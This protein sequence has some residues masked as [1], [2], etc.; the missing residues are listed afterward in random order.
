MGSMFGGNR[1]SGYN[2]AGYSG[3]VAP[4]SSSLGSSDLVRGR[5]F[6]PIAA[7]A[8]NSTIGKAM[9]N[10]PVSN[11]LFGKPKYVM[12]TAGPYA[13]IAP[14]L[15]G[16]Q[17]GYALDSKGQPA[18]PGAGTSAQLNATFGTAQPLGNNFAPAP[19]PAM[20][21]VPNATNPYVAASQKM[22]QPVNQGKASY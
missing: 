3:G 20:S 12:P 15:A 14:S 9:L 11:F 17:S 5:E 19:G 8:P 1:S 2:S 13:G 4:G 21:G 7:L 10:D 22:I 16:A 18:A 6:G